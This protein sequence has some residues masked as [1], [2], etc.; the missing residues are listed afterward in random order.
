MAVFHPKL[1]FGCSG[2]DQV[3]A[4]RGRAEIVAPQGCEGRH[5]AALGAA[6]DRAQRR[7][8]Q[9]V[10]A[11]VDVGGEGPVAVSHRARRE[12]DHG[13]VEPVESHVVVAALI[14]VEDKRHVARAL[15]RPSRERR[16]GR[17]E[18]RAH[19]VAV[20]VLEIVTGQLPL[21]LRC[22]FCLPAS[23]RVD[24]GM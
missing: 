10:G 24:S 8:L 17:D 9:V 23:A 14:D 6:E 21:L 20:A 1:T 16:A 18:A 12:N 11:L 7:R 13:N 15:A 4:G 5:G 19:H 2:K 3:S 22:H